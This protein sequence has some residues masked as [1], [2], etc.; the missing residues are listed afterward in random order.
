MMRLVVGNAQN[1]RI[2]GGS[3]E[4]W[5]VAK[6]GDLFDAPGFEPLAQL[7]TVFGTQPFVGDDVA[8]LPSRR[9]QRDT[10]LNEITVD[11][12]STGENLVDAL[13][14]RFIIA[15]GFL[16]DIR[17][18]ADD[19]IK[20]AGSKDVRE[21]ALPVEGVDAL[22]LFIIREH[23]PLEVIPADQRV[24]AADVVSQVGQ[25]ALKAERELT[26]LALE[27]FE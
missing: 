13:V 16:A 4:N 15:Q 2:G 24:V 23:L 6:V 18:V 22:D 10:L 11:I 26:G 9:E 12:G 20:A 25:D 3:G 8:E 7:E 1:E 17:R 14:I 27:Q 21:G 5:Q 19:G